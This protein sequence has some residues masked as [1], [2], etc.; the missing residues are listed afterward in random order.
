MIKITKQFTIE[1]ASLPISWEYSFPEGVFILENSFEDNCILTKFEVCDNQDYCGTLTITDKDSCISTLDFCLGSPCDDFEATISEIEDC[2]GCGSEFQVVTTQNATIEWEFDSTFIELEG[3]IN[4]STV[5]FID[6]NPGETVIRVKAINEND[7]EIYSNSLIY[8]ACVPTTVKQLIEVACLNNIV[9]TG[10]FTPNVTTCG[11]IID[12]TTFKVTE[13]IYSYSDQIVQ[14]NQL[15]HTVVVS[16]EEIKINFINDY[17]EGI[18][19]FKYSAEDCR[20]SLFTGEL[21]F[22]IEECGKLAY[23]LPMNLDLT[24]TPGKVKKSIKQFTS[25]TDYTTLVFSGLGGTLTNNQ[26]LDTPYGALTLDVNGDI[27]IDYNGALLS[28]TSETF[29]YTIG[30]GT[31][32]TIILNGDSRCAAIPDAAD[33]NICLVKNGELTLNIG[34]LNNELIDGVLI[35]TFPDP[36]IVTNLD[37]NNNIILN[38]TNDYVGTTTLD[39]RLQKDRLFGAKGTITIEVGLSEVEHN[40]LSICS[41]TISNFQVVSGLTTFEKLIYVGFGD[42]RVQGD[43]PWT[44]GDG[45]MGY[46]GSVDFTNLSCGNYYFE[47]DPSGECAGNVEITIEKVCA[48]S[49]VD[50]STEICETICDFDLNEMSGLDLQGDWTDLLG[51]SNLIGSK[52]IPCEL[53]PGIYSFR[54]N[55]DNQGVFNEVNCNSTL[56]FQVQIIEKN[57]PIVIPC[58]YTCSNGPEYIETACDV[59][60]PDPNQ[61]PECIYDFNSWIGIPSDMKIT[62]KSA[63]QNPISLYIDG[64][65]TPLNINDELPKNFAWGASVAPAGDYEFN[66]CYDDVCGQCLDIPVTILPGVNTNLSSEVTICRGDVTVNLN[67][68]IGTTGGVWTLISETI[69]SGGSS[70]YDL[71]TGAF[72]PQVSGIWVFNYMNIQTNGDADCTVCQV[73]F[74][75]TLIVN[76]VP[77]PGVPQPFSVCNDAACILDIYPDF[78]IVDLSQLGQFIY[79][80]YSPSSTA[81]PTDAG[82][83]WGG[84]QATPIEGQEL[85]PQITFQNATAGFYYFTNS[86]GEGDCIATATTIVQVVSVGVAGAGT[87]IEY[88]ND[89]DTCID[90]DALLVGATG[91][92]NWIITDGGLNLASTSCEAGIWI[93]AD[94]ATL[95]PLNQPPGIYIIDYVQTT[96]AALYPIQPECDTCNGGVASITITITQSADSGTGVSS[97]IC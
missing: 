47:Y 38:S 65:Y 25:E 41:G 7:C 82:G 42:D 69:T 18:V 68:L 95:N 24:C 29:Q 30:D 51:N 36:N 4:S 53:S 87:S 22:E 45:P 78:F 70:S 15:E 74:T 76:P 48:D 23:T 49:L 71:V 52:I 96:P 2:D 97:A 8:T 57:A 14:I 43:Y 5:K 72:T 31:V 32:G 50:I 75:F 56:V 83:G 64:V 79:D 40:D 21:C 37:S 11:E 26:Q 81:G 1:N 34:D 12:W 54:F 62:L 17:P 88:C 94:Q 35:S 85:P 86:V 6:K 60:V 46:G 16:E 9:T 67:D 73:D 66:A 19:T 91:G 33:L 55:K 89:Q 80:G 93:G 13:E 20:G 39:Y 61:V 44:I 3:N 92:G 63:P 59:V 77:G 58:F 27:V 28:T 84:V 10:W 90:L